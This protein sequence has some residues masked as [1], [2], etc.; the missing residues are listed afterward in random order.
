MSVEQGNPT[1]SEKTCPNGT[2]STTNPACPDLGSNP[3]RRSEKPVTN[4]LSYGMARLRECYAPG[5]IKII[6]RRITIMKSFK[7]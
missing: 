1:Y 3:D 6:A 7:T 4:H 2:L 5:R